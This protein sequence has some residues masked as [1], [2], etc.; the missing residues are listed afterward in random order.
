MSEY[1]Y[2]KVTGISVLL[3]LVVVYAIWPWVPYDWVWARS[4]SEGVISWVHFF[5]VLSFAIYFFR[6]LVCLENDVFRRYLR[7]SVGVIVIYLAAVQL[8]GAIARGN[9][10]ILFRLPR[11]A[12]QEVLALGQGAFGGT[13]VNI[14][15]RQR[16][17]VVFTRESLIRQYG[18]ASVVGLVL[19]PDNGLKVELSEYGR[20]NYF[21]KIEPAE[22]E[23]TVKH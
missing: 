3:L 1:K 14:V 19:T 7:V 6:K 18:A 21:E 22:I 8:A 10:V 23:K 15:V 4:S 2:F 5:I 11:G 20:A 9:T 17:G 16:T 13:W 12:D